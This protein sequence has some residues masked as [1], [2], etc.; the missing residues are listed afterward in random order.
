MTA[1]L[2]IL[3]NVAYFTLMRH[4]HANSNMAAKLLLRVASRNNA[5]ARDLKLPPRSGGE[6]GPLGL[7]TL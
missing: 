7:L 6:L 3:V 1:Q 2:F 5:R 4:K